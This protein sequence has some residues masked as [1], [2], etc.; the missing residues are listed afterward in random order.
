MVA[1]SLVV[2]NYSGRGMVHLWVIGF[3]SSSLGFNSMPVHVGFL[4]NQCMDQCIDQC[5]DQFTD[6]CM[7]QC[8][9]QCSVFIFHIILALEA[10]LCEQHLSPSFSTIGSLVVFPV[11]LLCN[12]NAC[13][14]HRSVSNEVLSLLQD[15][16]VDLHRAVGYSFLTLS[17]TVGL[18]V[19]KSYKK[20]LSLYHGMTYF[21]FFV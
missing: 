19:Y 11:F 5:T 7:D 20:N 21:L 18:T 8:M 17:T 10:F 6:Q 3:S 9:D 15:R 16:A 12:T 13:T 2:S 14:Y 1:H 4:M